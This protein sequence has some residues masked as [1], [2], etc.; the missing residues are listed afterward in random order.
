MGVVLPGLL[1]PGQAPL[2]FS[3]AGRFVPAGSLLVRRAAFRHLAD[4]AV[5]P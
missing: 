5:L 4:L 3:A 2:L 1:G